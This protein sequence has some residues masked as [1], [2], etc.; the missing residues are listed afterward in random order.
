MGRVDISAIQ[1]L[2]SPYPSR[3]KDGIA[4]L[5]TSLCCLSLCPCR[6]PAWQQCFPPGCGCQG[7]RRTQEGFALTEHL[8]VGGKCFIPSACAAQGAAEPGLERIPEPIKEATALFYGESFGCW[9]R[10]RGCCGQGGHPWGWW[11]ED[12]PEQ[13]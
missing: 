5:N 4:G 12:A 6:V 7:G 1:G 9:W 13:V 2:S 8:R 3:T 11:R 10:P